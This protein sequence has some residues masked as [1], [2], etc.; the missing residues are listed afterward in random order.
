M[1][2]IYYE[3][4]SKSHDFSCFSVFY[5]TLVILIWMVGQFLIHSVSFIFSYLF[6]FSIYDPMKIESS[7]S[8]GSETQQ[9]IEN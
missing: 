9:D 4:S 5:L 1:K 2:H 6:Y 7:K 3:K 8:C